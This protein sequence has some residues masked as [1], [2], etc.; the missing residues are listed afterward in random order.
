MKIRNDIGS[1]LISEDASIL[2][3]MKVIDNGQERTAFLVGPDRKLIKVI[4]DG[5]IRR[6]I[7]RGVGIHDPVIDIHD[8]QPHVFFELFID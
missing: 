5:D 3:A 1:Y 4:T 7:L 6:A 8:R 2:D